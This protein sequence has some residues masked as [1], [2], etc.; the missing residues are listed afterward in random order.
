MKTAGN[1]SF[2]GGNSGSISGLEAGLSA[3]DCS[4]SARL[5]Q[6]SVS[7]N[8]KPKPFPDCRICSRFPITRAAA[9]GC[10]RIIQAAALIFYEQPQSLTPQKDP[11]PIFRDHRGA[12]PSKKFQSVFPGAFFLRGSPARTDHVT[13]GKKY[14]ILAVTL[15]SR[16]SRTVLGQASPWQCGF[17]FGMDS[18]KKLSEQTEEKEKGQLEGEALSDASVSGEISLLEIKKRR[19]ESGV[20]QCSV[21]AG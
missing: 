17:L 14:H 9:G 20:F 15:L 12:D 7:R 1:V 5:K 10:R 21:S 13:C 2:G 6:G 16:E 11:H 18:E 8:R 4:E 3:A 19:N